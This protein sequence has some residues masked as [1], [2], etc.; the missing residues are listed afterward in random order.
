MPH[1]I[2]RWQGEWLIQ[3]LLAGALLDYKTTPEDGVHPKGK[4][5]L[6]RP[7]SIFI[8]T[9]RFWRNEVGTAVL[10]GTEVVL[11]I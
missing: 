3:T 6:T 7:T 5:S 2:T 9:V 8:T 10:C 11:G 4:Q 1:H